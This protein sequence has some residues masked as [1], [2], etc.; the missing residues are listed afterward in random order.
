MTFTV[1]D[2][3]ALRLTFD[4]WSTLCS[5]AS[6]DYDQ[7]LVGGPMRKDIDT[8]VLA[9]LLERQRCMT[10]GGWIDR[11]TVT[12]NG[13]TASIMVDKIF[14]WEEFAYVSGWDDDD[15]TEPFA[16]II[17]LQVPMFV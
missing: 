14:D 3:R 1:S 10:E 13:R 11:W 17:N 15:S 9:G 7:S 12:E 2:L 4:E 16:K 8:L 5:M 6:N